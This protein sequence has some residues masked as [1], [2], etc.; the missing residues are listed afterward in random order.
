LSSGRSPARAKKNAAAVPLIPP[1][2]MTT[3]A[4]VGRSAGMLFS[5]MAPLFQVMMLIA[6]AASMA[7]VINE[8]DA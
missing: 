8:T 3:S 1:P 5:D 2:M 4:V 6:R 7:S